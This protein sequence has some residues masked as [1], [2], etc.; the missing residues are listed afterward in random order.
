M[1]TSSLL[2]N[3]KW[4]WPLQVFLAISVVQAVVNITFESYSIKSLGFTPNP[5]HRT[6]LYIFYD[7]GFIAAQTSALL[8]AF[9]ALHVRSEPLATAATA[10]DLL[11]LALQAA[12]LIQSGVQL[13]VVTMQAISIGILALGLVAKGWIVWRYLKRDFGWQVYRALGADLKMQHMFFCQQLLLS[14]VILSGFLFVELWL[15][16]AEI[17]ALSSSNSGGCWVQHAFLLVAAI[18]VLCLCLFAAVQEL[19]WLMYGC[20]GTFAAALA[21]F[22][23]QLVVV[24]RERPAEAKDIFEAS[25]KYIN[26]L[27]AMMVALTVA[28]VTISLV[29]AW[30]FGRG[31]RQ[32]LRQ[33]Q[34]LARQEVDLEALSHQD[35]TANSPI[36]TADSNTV[37]E[38]HNKQSSFRQTASDILTML[39][40]DTMSSLKESSLLFQ[41]FF[42][43]LDV[44]TDV[45]VSFS[46]Q[47]PRNF[48]H[49][50]RIAA[51]A[52]RLQDVFRLPSDN[53]CSN[54]D[55]DI[56][57]IGYLYSME[58][59]T[60]APSI[61]S[62]KSEYK[63]TPHPRESSLG[64]NAVGISNVDDSDRNSV[65]DNSNNIPQPM[66]SD[67]SPVTPGL[68]LSIEELDVINSD[69]E[70]IRSISR[71]HTGEMVTLSARTTASWSLVS[72]ISFRT[73]ISTVADA[74]ESP[75]HELSSSQKT[76]MLYPANTND[77][78]V[79]FND[80]LQQ[81]LDM[82]VTNPD[83]DSNSSKNYS[84]LSISSI[85]PQPEAMH[86]MISVA[87]SAD[88]SVRFGEA[89][90]ATILNE[91]FDK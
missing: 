82:R 53:S 33:F 45:P 10:F 37:N 89:S 44:P 78:S 90:H 77:D 8:L 79:L 69:V 11:L 41:A 40:T 27:L 2:R 62:E 28:L 19:P 66:A 81:P 14:L 75:I 29:V 35:P 87:T 70:T 15:Q 38:K 55:G 56:R 74:V 32:R 22:I 5:S 86:S 60:A 1:L 31:L 88:A 36:D 21:F 24:N 12:Q 47:S 17:A 39:A 73:S 68:L 76:Q 3:D 59:N 83:V 51:S 71:P 58:H 43:G 85:E 26:F 20:I 80:N 52:P 34:I 25:L 61:L 9:T 7:G 18:V 13:S 16:L 4:S 50:M 46:D 49:P 23:Y 72:S 91:G 48:V 67:A 65:E 6:L 42:S 84:A 63:S 64:S 30:S 57:S 54:F